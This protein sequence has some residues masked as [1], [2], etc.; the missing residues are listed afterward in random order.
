MI[1]S[2][3][4][5]EF[6]EQRLSAAVYFLVDLSVS[7]DNDISIEI[8]SPT[9]V[10]IDYCAELTRE[11]EAEFDRDADDYSLE[12]GSAGLTAP[13]RVRGQYEKNLGNE[14][15]V[16]TTDGRK[17]RGTLK[18][19]GSDDFTLAVEQKVKREGQKRPSVETVDL[20]IPFSETKYTKYL[21]DF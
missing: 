9:G 21:L 5:K 19:L 12:V 1:D 3:K 11:I 8:D 17:L 16:L 20:T 2:Q 4:L 18:S 7:A 6:V 13:F 15:E 14:V 10:D